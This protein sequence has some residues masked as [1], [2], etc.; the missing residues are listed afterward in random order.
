MRVSA[1][2]P[3]QDPFGEQSS[4]QRRVPHTLLGARFVF[5][6]VNP[7]LLRLAELAYRGLPA[8]AGRGAPKFDLEL[9]LVRASSRRRRRPAALRPFA[10]PNGVLGGIMDADNFVLLSPADGSGLISVSSDMLRHP[11][12]VRYELIEFAVYTLASR[13]RQLLSLHAGCVARA[14]RALLLMGSTG[15]GKSTV[16]LHCALRG[17]DLLSEDAAFVDVARLQAV[18][19]PNFAYVRPPAIALIGNADTAARVRRAPL[20]RRRSGIAK[21]E[22]DLRRLGCRLCSAPV[23]LAAIVFLGPPLDSGQ[24]RLR[25]LSPRQTMRRFEAL[26]AYATRLPRWPAFRRRLESL[27]GFELQRGWHPDQSVVALTHLLRKLPRP[28]V[29]RGN[30]RRVPRR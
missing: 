16:A 26:Q 24:A 27:P 30:G 28:P 14:G 12:L 20:I 8:A 7:R 4:V 15:S 23:S 17:L 25:A 2:N 11:Y 21:R 18:G 19:V 10:A 1:S 9:R 5:R 29:P 13:A 6:S 3:E 22:V